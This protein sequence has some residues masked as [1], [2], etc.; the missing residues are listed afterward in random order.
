MS[1]VV[2][3][4]DFSR[5]PGPR[6]KSLGEFSGEEFRT[7]VLVPK[8]HENGDRLVIDLDGTMGYGSSFLEESF[9]GLIRT[10]GLEPSLILKIVGN[11]ISNEDPSLK[12][13]IVG[14]VKDAIDEKGNGSE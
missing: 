4:L 13:E 11:T 12:D 14:Y 2:K 5:F 10:E 8:I 7:A 3:V 1:V 6:F 9:G